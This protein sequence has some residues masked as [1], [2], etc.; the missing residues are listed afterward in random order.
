MSPIAI[1]TDQHGARKH[2]KLAD[3]KICKGATPFDPTGATRAK[4]DQ[5]A[6]RVA[7]PVVQRAVD[8]ATGSVAPRVGNKGGDA[9]HP[10]AAE[11][12]HI[13]RDRGASA[14]LGLEAREAAVALMREVLPMVLREEMRGSMRDELRAV[15]MEVHGSEV[16]TDLQTRLEA[17]Q[18]QLAAANAKL[19]VAVADREGLRGQVEG[20][21]AQV[22]ELQAK[23]VAG[24]QQQQRRPQGTGNA[25]AHGSLGARMRAEVAESQPGAVAAV[26]SMVAAANST[27]AVCEADRQAK[28]LKMVGL[29]ETVV[30]TDRL[31][32]EVQ[33]LVADHCRDQHGRP[34]A[35]KVV[36]A[37]RVGLLGEG[38]SDEERPPRP[39]AF[40]LAT[41]GQARD[42]MRAKRGFRGA[43]TT[44]PIFVDPYLT[45]EEQLRFQQLL[46]EYRRL[47]AAEQRVFWRRDRLMVVRAGGA[48]VEVR[49]G[50]THQGDGAEEQVKGQ[51]EGVQE[52]PKAG[53]DTDMGEAD[54]ERAAES[55]NPDRKT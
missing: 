52:D 51:V 32:K 8:S 45:H 49:A 30:G 24:E 43:G 13:S 38:T 48:V 12:E 50:R 31:C 44:R 19:D 3:G 34:L 17:T 10:D 9:M 27:A 40:E 33:Q 6:V 21:S 23:L 25:W 41:A 39:V 28:L 29:P 46:P 16:V 11:G 5:R 47:R 15:I 7:T 37:W 42:L 14:W 26:A 22:E 55:E 54:G 53:R 4:A 2:M 20:L 35:L 36:D 1:D 18:T